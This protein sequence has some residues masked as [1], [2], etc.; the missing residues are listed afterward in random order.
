M[1][2]R[3]ELIKL[4]IQLADERFLT[5]APET[6]IQKVRDRITKLQREIDEEVAVEVCACEVCK[7]KKYAFQL[8]HC[9]VTVDGE[10]HV[11]AAR[12][13]DEG[14][15]GYRWYF[16]PTTFEIVL[17]YFDPDTGMPSGVSTTFKFKNIRSL[18]RAWV[19]I[20]LYWTSANY[21]Y[22][23]PPQ[24]SFAFMDEY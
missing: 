6:A 23:R 5:K 8:E 4:R 2:K 21:F 15:W 7:T 10:T 19:H 11:V 3:D 17:N 13:I 9:V 1:T 20:N 14:E 22:P 18:L 12:K 24:M 16:I